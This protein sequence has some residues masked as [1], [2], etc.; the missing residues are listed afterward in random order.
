MDARQ[1]KY[2][3]AVCRLKSLTHAAD[4]CNVAPSALSHHIANLEAELGVTLFR[5]KPR[6]MEPT[7]SGL[8]LL[9]HARAILSAIDTAIGDLRDGETEVSGEITVGMPYSVIKAI[10]AAVMRAVL[11]DYP[12][13]RLILREGLSGATH[14]TLK[15]GA[16]DLALIFNPPAEPETEREPLL[17]EELFCIGAP[18]V[19][20]DDDGPITFDDMT[21]L[22]LMLLQSGVLARAL[23]DKPGALARLE[24]AARIQLA[25]VAAT[26]AALLEGL[27]CTLAPK[28][29]V[30]ELLATGAVIARRVTDPRPIRTLY[31]LTNRDAEPTILREH[32]AALIRSLVH[33]AI[34]DERWPA[35]QSLI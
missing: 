17:T 35:A 19:I 13:V 7:A 22:P 8:R 18:A 31:M 23:V 20:G 11:N 9:A 14:S 6:G 3:V 12:R 2:F 10:G 32:M 15:T 21:A 26:Q 30:P 25:S 5:R 34:I 33:R 16:L 29:L 24:A 28:V 1:L 27:G 4:H